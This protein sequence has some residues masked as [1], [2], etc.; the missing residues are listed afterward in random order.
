[1]PREASWEWGL[2][3]QRIRHGREMNLA[4]LAG[5]SVEERVRPSVVVAS[6]RR[7]RRR[8]LSLATKS[9]AFATGSGEPLRADFSSDLPIGIE[10]ENFANSAAAMPAEQRI[11][12]AAATLLPGRRY[13]AAVIAA[14]CELR[15]PA[16]ACQ[17]QWQISHCRPSRDMSCRY[18]GTDVRD[19]S[20]QWRMHST[21]IEA[22]R[23]ASA[24]HVEL[25]AWPADTR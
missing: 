20:A 9:A 4:H 2:P 3:L 14:F 11:R 25:V 19:S 12:L 13:G 23:L 22:K 6:D 10:A 15:L 16:S 18:E 7:R 8:L 1:M 24:L 21:G 17:R 5:A